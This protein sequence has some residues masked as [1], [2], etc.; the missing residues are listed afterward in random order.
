MSAGPSSTLG[1]F[2]NDIFTS[3]TGNRYRVVRGLGEGTF[4]RVYEV[5]RVGGNTERLALK[6]YKSTVSLQAILEELSAFELLSHSPDCNEMFVCLHE[7][8]R[9]VEPEPPKDSNEEE[10][11]IGTALVLEFMEGG[12]GEEMIQLWLGMKQPQTPIQ[13]RIMTMRRD[14]DFIINMATRLLRGLTYIHSRGV[15]HM[16]IKPANVLFDSN[17]QLKYGDPGIVCTDPSQE[18]T[19]QNI[20]LCMSHMTTPL[21]AAPETWLYMLGGPPEIFSMQINVD[22]A[23]K[24]D[25]WAAGITLMMFV[26]MITFRDLD[27]VIQSH[28]HMFMEE[29]RRIRPEILNEVPESVIVLIDKMLTVNPNK[30]PTAQD[31]LNQFEHRLFCTDRP[32]SIDQLKETVRRDTQMTAYFASRNI[33]FETTQNIQELCGYISRY[34]GAVARAYDSPE[35][36]DVEGTVLT[37]DSLMEFSRVLGVNVPESGWN[38]VQEQCA[39][40]NTSLLN[41]RGVDPRAVFLILERGVDRLIAADAGEGLLNR[42]NVA[43]FRLQRIMT[44]IATAFSSPQLT[45]LIQNKITTQINRIPDQTLRRKRRM[46]WIRML[47]ANARG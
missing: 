24:M 34:W 35:L 38:S 46:Y 19:R 20:Y 8:F 47:P 23:Q 10:N 36:C 30:R 28:G 25:V 12:D 15:A 31:L 4:G 37:R 5:V 41:L 26:Y 44:I 1:S 42:P 3:P 27:Q 22:T 16:D 9:F 33:D 39:A 6:V 13:Q 2:R 45:Q 18:E 32:V 43:N 40:V 21:I 14:H 11:V 7:T 29:V 17:L